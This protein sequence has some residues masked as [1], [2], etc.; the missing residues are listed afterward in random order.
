MKNKSEIEQW[1]YEE[2][3]KTNGEEIP[4]LKQMCIEFQITMNNAQ[5][6]REQFIEDIIEELPTQMELLSKAYQ[7]E[8]A[9]EKQRKIDGAKGEVLFFY[10][11]I[12]FHWKKAEYNT[13]MK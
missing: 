1:L 9:G 3:R 10:I 6:I 11:H 12:L 8:N 2:I 7:K 4:S 13:K 5:E